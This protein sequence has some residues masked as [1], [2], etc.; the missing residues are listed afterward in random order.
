M[1]HVREKVP[2]SPV[3]PMPR[4]TTRRRKTT[5]KRRE[6]EKKNIIEKKAKEVP[7]N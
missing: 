4:C 2:K 7:M 1:Q 6:K 3:D 5:K